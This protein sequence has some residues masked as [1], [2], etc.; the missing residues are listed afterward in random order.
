MFAAKSN[1]YRFGTQYLGHNVSS[2]THALSIRNLVYILV[3]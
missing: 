2:I 3:I 1:L